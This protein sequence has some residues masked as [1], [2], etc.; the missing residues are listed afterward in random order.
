[1][2]TLVS[3]LYLYLLT[4]SRGNICIG[5]W[6]NRSQT[7]RRIS[8]SMCSS[9]LSSS[10]IRG[11]HWLQPDAADHLLSL[12]KL[13]EG[14]LYISTLMDDLAVRRNAPVIIWAAGYWTWLVSFCIILRYQ[15][16]TSCP[17]FCCN[18]P[19]QQPLGRLATRVGHLCAVYRYIKKRNLQ[20]RRPTK[21][22]SPLYLGLWFP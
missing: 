16:S 6:S 12:H 17:Y 14:E 11:F 7:M 2:G 9:F 3:V 15:L 5:L 1:M 8:S 18:K 21:R 10:I 20:I 4:G 19:S 22:F 13:C